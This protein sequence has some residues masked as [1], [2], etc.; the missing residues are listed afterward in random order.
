MMMWMWSRI[1]EILSHGLVDSFEMEKERL[2]LLEMKQFNCVCGNMI[3]NGIDVNQMDTVDPA[4]DR[5]QQPTAN[6]K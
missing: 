4:S 3:V 5:H 6:M 1:F 2:F